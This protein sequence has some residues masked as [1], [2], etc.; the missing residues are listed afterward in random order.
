MNFCIRNRRRAVSL[1]LTSLL[2]VAAVAAQTD[3]S[4]YDIMKRANDRP[5]GNDMTASVLMKIVSKSGTIKTREFI[6]YQLRQKEGASS[7]LIKFSQPADVKGTSFLT[8][9]SSKNEK[10]Q[11]IYLPSLKKATRISASDKNKPFMGSDLTYDDFGSRNV[12]DY[13]FSTL[14]DESFS[15]RSCWKIESVPKDKSGGTSR[16]VS[17][18]D[19]ESLIVV[20]ADFYDKSGALYKQMAVSQSEKISGIWTIVDLEMKNLTTGG[21]TTL[22]FDAVKYDT[23][24]STS[25]FSKESLGK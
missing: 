15:G 23:G 5:S 2:F 17:L 21:S 8:S 6:M 7:T 19:K 10:S 22:H 25:L 3:N 11:Y 13:T 16:I 14:G 12:D 1:V 18:V 4:G 20:K 24:L 9:E